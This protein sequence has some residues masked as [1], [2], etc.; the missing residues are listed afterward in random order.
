MGEEKREDHGGG[1]LKDDRHSMLCHSTIVMM[2]P[3]EYRL[4]V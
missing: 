4:P 1:K 3:M 2:S